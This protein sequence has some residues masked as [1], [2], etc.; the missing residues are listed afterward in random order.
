MPDKITRE[1]SDYPDSK[2]W[3]D[4]VAENMVPK[5]MDSVMVMSL[6]TDSEPDVK[7]AVEIGMAILLNKPL[8]AVVI[9]GSVVP[10]KLR[11]IADEIVEVDLDTKDGKQ[12]LQDAMSRITKSLE[13]E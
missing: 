12:A 8:L 6:V 7:F 13:D 3:L 4:D 1:W 10:P 9:K 2:A 5:M 11:L